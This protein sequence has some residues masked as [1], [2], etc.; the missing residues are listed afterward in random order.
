MN[1]DAMAYENHVRGLLLAIR[2][3]IARL[4]IG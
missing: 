1:Q 4:S 2:Q 3:E